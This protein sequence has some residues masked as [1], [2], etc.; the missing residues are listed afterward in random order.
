MKQYVW[1]LIIVGCLDI[2]DVMS[3]VEHQKINYFLKLSHYYSEDLIRVFYY[4]LYDRRCSSFK[5]TIGN[6]VYEFT[7]DL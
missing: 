6:I 1:K 3:L 4:G 5:F 7:D 2:P